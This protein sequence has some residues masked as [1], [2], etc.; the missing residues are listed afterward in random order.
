MLLV[1][2]VV[3]GYERKWNVLCAALTTDDHDLRENRNGLVVSFS[4]HF[5]LKSIYSQKSL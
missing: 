2:L 5:P 1:I 3:T 4:S